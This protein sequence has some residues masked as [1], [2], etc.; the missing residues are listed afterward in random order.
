MH[1]L[2]CAV[3]AVLCACMLN[4]C[5]AG[6]QVTPL[7]LPSL[8]VSCLQLHADGCE[9]R[10]QDLSLRMSALEWRFDKVGPQSVVGVQITHQGQRTVFQRQCN[11]DFF[12]QSRHSP[13]CIP[14]RAR[15]PP[16]RPY[17]RWRRGR[18]SCGGSWW[19]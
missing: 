13:P 11:A 3:S 14:C 10:G 9:G 12:C 5:A 7:L 19:G 2:C 8:Q 16:S 18:T 1:L 6:T 17:T 15:A 4:W